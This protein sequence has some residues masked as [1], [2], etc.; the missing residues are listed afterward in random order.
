ME[1]VSVQIPAKLYVSIYQL[2]G[3]DSGPQIVR[4][5]EELCAIKPQPAPAGS[6]RPGPGTITGKVWLIADELKAASG[7]ANRSEVVAACMAQ[8]INMNTA[9]TQYSHWLKENS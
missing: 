7:S 3:E 5:L 1:L 2:H 4:A 9:S 6:F 8:G